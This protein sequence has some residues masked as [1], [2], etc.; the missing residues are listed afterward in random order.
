[1]PM[2]EMGTGRGSGQARGLSIQIDCKAGC[3]Q[4]TYNNEGTHAQNQQTRRAATQPVG[5]DHVSV[6][7]KTW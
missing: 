6:R 1:C 2:Q 5:T 4:R 3:I 7:Y